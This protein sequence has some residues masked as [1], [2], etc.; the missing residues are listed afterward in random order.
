MSER[1]MILELAEVLRGVLEGEQT[2]DS[3][4]TRV[5]HAVTGPAHVTAQVI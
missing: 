4:G 5:N 1:N 2:K 3:E